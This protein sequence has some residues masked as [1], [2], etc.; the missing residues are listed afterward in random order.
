[1]SCMH[2]CHV[3]EYRFPDRRTNYGVWLSGRLQ[4][5]NRAQSNPRSTCI[6]P[7]LV[8]SQTYKVTEKKHVWWL[9]KEYDCSFISSDL[10]FLCVEVVNI[11]FAV[12][13]AFT[14]ECCSTV[15]SDIYTQSVI[16][17]QLGHFP[18]DFLTVVSLSVWFL[19]LSGQSMVIAK[20]EWWV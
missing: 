12:R 6:C 10:L 7:P 3:S 16:K 15:K 19:E 13:Y 8:Q 14:V 18:L 11:A 5:Y 17:C 4:P 20:S 1:M 2:D 9:C